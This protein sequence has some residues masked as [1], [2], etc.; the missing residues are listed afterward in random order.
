MFLL[1][2]FLETKI[3]CKQ[4][5]TKKLSSAISYSS[6]SSTRVRGTALQC[7]AVRPKSSD[8]ETGCE[9][10]SSWS[11]P[12]REEPAVC[13]QDTE[14]K[15]YKRT[16]VADWYR[17]TTETKKRIINAK[18]EVFKRT[19]YRQDS[20]WSNKKTG[21]N[22]VTVVSI[23]FHSITTLRVERRRWASH[24]VTGNASRE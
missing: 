19:R 1:N 12:L 18:K 13:R 21:N 6:N 4:S 10:T 11:M 20:R 22:Y 9:S 14:A 5:S 2:I 24:S 15:E 7:S 8:G 3:L 23:E 16:A 17:R